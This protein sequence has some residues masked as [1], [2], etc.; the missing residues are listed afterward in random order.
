MSTHPHWW[1]NGVD[2]AEIIIWDRNR[3]T[4]A[5]E[6]SKSKSTTLCK[7][8]GRGRIMKTIPRDTLL[9]TKELKD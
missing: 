2:Q 7:N 9:P 8:I 1:V 6:K 5:S 4:Y 3:P